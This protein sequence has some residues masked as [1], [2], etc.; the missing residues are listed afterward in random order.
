MMNKTH[1]QGLKKA[2]FLAWLSL[3]TNWLAA[4]DWTGNLK[5]GSTYYITSL[6]SGTSFKVVSA[7]DDNF[8]NKTY[9]NI[10]TINVSHGGTSIIVFNT[11]KLV[12]CTSPIRV[13]NGTLQ[14]EIGNDATFDHPTL[15]RS[16]NNINMSMISINP[17]ADITD[18]SNCRLI[19]K[20]IH[21]SDFSKNFVIHGGCEMQIDSTNQSD[22]RFVKTS[23][24]FFQ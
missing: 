17:A 5:A 12:Y 23:D 9:D 10:G 14:M 1:G 11:T 15:Q 16:P 4:A 21:T 13:T 18:P 22:I 19:L 8:N 7:T 3:L 20:G 2:L 24:V 6:S